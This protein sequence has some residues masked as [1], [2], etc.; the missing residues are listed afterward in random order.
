MIKSVFKNGSILEVTV[1]F[2]PRVLHERRVRFYTQDALEFVKQSYPDEKIV[3]TMAGS[4]TA[5]LSNYAEPY[6]GVWQ[7]RIF[8][9]PDEDFVSMANKFE[10]KKQLNLDEGS[11]TLDVKNRP[12]KRKEKEI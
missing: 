1:K 11:V 10:E 6:Q 3:E 9:D 5:T 8:I 4:Q 12:K 2:E 7:F